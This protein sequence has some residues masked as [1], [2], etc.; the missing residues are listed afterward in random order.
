[1]LMFIGMLMV[2]DGIWSLQIVSLQP[3]YAKQVDAGSETFMLARRGR[4]G[5]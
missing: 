4:N 1:M 5:P 2:I 3:G